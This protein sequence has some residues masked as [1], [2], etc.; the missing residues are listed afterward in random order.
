[1]S[2][3]V[4]FCRNVIAGAGVFIFLTSIASI[5]AQHSQWRSELG[6]LGAAFMCLTIVLEVNRCEG[7][8]HKE[9]F[10]KRRLAQSEHLPA[11]DDELGAIPEGQDS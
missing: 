6:Q 4:K 3:K 2:P 1:M 11:S 9:V 7:D 8:W 10:F 5:V